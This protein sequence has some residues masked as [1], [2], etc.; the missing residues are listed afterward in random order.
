MTT[1]VRRRRELLA[2]AQ[3]KTFDLLVIGGGITGAGIARQAAWMNISMAL[4]EQADFASGTSSRSSKLLHGGLRYLAQGN[5]RL[6][7]E[8]VRERMAVY[9]A[10]PHLV[11]PLP[12][13]FPQFEGNYPGMIRLAIGIWIYHAMIGF[14][15]FG[16][17]Q[18]LSAAEIEKS[19]PGIRTAGLDGGYQYWDAQ[20]DDARLT[21]EIILDAEALGATALNRVRLLAARQ[22]NG[23]WICDV[24]DTST[25]AEFSIRTQSVA[26]AVG[27]WMDRMARI[28]DAEALRRM[29]PTQG[30]HI[31]IPSAR[32]SVPTAIVLLHPDDQRFMYA[33]PMESGT[34]IGTTDTDCSEPAVE[35][36]VDNDSIDYLLRAANHFFPDKKLRRDD[37]FSMY[38]GLR[39]LILDDDVTASK[40]SREHA[41]YQ[42]ATNVVAIGGGKLTTWRPMANDAIAQILPSLRTTDTPSKAAD[43]EYR[44]RP[45]PG[46]VGIADREVLAGRTAEITSGYGLSM[47]SA[48]T[49]VY[50]YGARADAVLA[51]AQSVAGGMKTY[52]RIGVLAGA[53]VFNVL[54]EHALTLDDLMRRRSRLYYTEYDQGRAV[55]REIAEL[56]A[57]HVEW[58]DSRVD[59]EVAAYLEL[60][61]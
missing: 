19:I 54:H 43:R 1:P 49:V 35:P 28:F 52:G 10:A 48:E 17:H 22:E 29:R 31:L 38:A 3:E 44:D 27:P 57:P 6:V 36:T 25:A 14:K 60:C 26:V 2:R 30:V 51:T 24:E 61:L 12:F 23:L 15:S 50:T 13:L 37:V 53:F 47:E 4:I 32:L 40:V 11:R 45:L 9:K 39:P 8:A 5:F 56:V 21:L 42:L 41:V 59:A 55:A 58:D 33:I 7:R 46:G 34:L 16:P 20:T 18:R